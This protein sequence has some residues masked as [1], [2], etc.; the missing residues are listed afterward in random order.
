MTKEDLINQITEEIKV[1]DELG[2][3]YEFT[4]K[5]IVAIFDSSKEYLETNGYESEATT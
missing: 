4:A 3:E 1:G 2:H 5:N